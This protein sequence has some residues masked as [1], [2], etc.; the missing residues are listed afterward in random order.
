MEVFLDCVPC[1]LRQVLEASR[2]ATDRA[3]IQE[4]IMKEAMAIIADYRKYRYSPE[5]GRIMHQVVKK[6]TGVS[7]PYKEL[8]K[9]NI[10]T[11]LQIYPL[12]KQFLEKKEDKLYWALKI[13]V[14]GNIIDAAIYHDINI[15]DIVERELEKEFRVCDLEKLKSELTQAKSLLIIG[16]NAGETVFDRVL[17][18][19]FSGLD[20]IYAVRSEPIINDAT[21]EDLYASGFTDSIRL[22]STGCN[23]P[24]LIL[25]ECAAEFVEIYNQADIVISK[26]QGNYETLSDQKRGV[27]FLLKA[28]CPAVAKILGVSINDYVFK[29]NNPGKEKSLS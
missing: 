25:D 21:I 15:T 12:L 17:V 1:L 7:D 11:A 16:D 20:L 18:E 10:Q 2:L 9:E 4:E 13:A 24:G 29:W 14:T 19:Y 27:F 6:H 26:G 28:K 5:I 3:E 22:I 23:A 8:K